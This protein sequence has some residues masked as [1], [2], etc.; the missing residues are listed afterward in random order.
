MYAPAVMA[1]AWCA[2]C[3]HCRCLLCAL[4]KKLPCGNDRAKYRLK[5]RWKLQ[6][7]CSMKNAMRLSIWNRIAKCALRYYRIRIWKPRITIS[8]TTVTALAQPA[9]NALKPHAP[10]KN[11]WVIPLRIGNSSRLHRISQATARAKN[12][13]RLPALVLRSVVTLLKQKWLRHLH[14]RRSAKLKTVPVPG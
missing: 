2:I 5:Y 11:N 1:L 8:S 3:V 9:M 7:F 6:R 4:L 12:P 10:V 14:K 13:L